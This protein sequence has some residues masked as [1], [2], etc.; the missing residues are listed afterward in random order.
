MSIGAITKVFATCPEEKSEYLVLIAMADQADD[1]GGNI[2]F[3]WET[4]AHKA[5]IDERTAQ[6][7][8][9]KLIKKGRVRVETG[10]APRGY[11]LYQIV[12]PAQPY[13]RDT[14]Q[15]NREARRLEK[16][17]TGKTA[18]GKKRKGEDPETASET[19][20]ETP[21]EKFSDSEPSTKSEESSE[22]SENF[23][24]KSE[25]FSVGTP[26]PRPPS[27]AGVAPETSF[28][29][30]LKR[31]VSNV[32]EDPRAEEDMSP[33]PLADEPSPPPHTTLQASPSEHIGG[34]TQ[35]SS[36]VAVLPPDG[37][38]ADAASITDS[39]LDALFGIE[40]PAT[41]ETSTVQ[42]SE[43]VP[44]GPAAP[45]SGSRPDMPLPG[46]VAA[47]AP[48]PAGELAQRP[49]AVPADPVYRLVVGLVGG[50]KAVDDG[51]LESLTPSGAIPR[52]HWLALTEEEIE[53]AK[54]AAQAEAKATG[55][56]FITLSIRALDRLIGAP[57][58]RPKPGE[59]VA[60]PTA[61]LTPAQ[62]AQQLAALP[63][64]NAGETW[65]S[66]RTGKRFIIEEVT[67]K[68]IFVEGVGEYPLQKFHQTF[69]SAEASA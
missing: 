8:V 51:I 37:G 54:V 4:I 41:P 62:Q 45:E 9:E 61:Y 2:W 18:Y 3:K 25:N 29:H 23:S 15:K 59:A 49:R 20:P 31:S 48:V 22:K 7:I 34:Q 64:V 52:A 43:N 69:R 39:E 32:V 57:L 24:E 12:F 58:H 16:R 19:G 53:T 30:P 67:S 60:A 10:A 46:A 33:A 36:S 14:F 50:R 40:S 55:V 44:R 68:S 42:S 38:A 56:S 63:P 28:K 35:P 66:R 1:E 21:S 17:A 27:A 47:L 5:R 65:A 11:D 6:M 13:T 26:V